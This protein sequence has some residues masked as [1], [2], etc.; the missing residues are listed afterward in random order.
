MTIG[1]L[2][3]VQDAVELGLVDDMN[4]MSSGGGGR[5][6]LPAGD[7]FIRLSTYVEFGVQPLPAF[8]GQ[9]KQPHMTVH[10]CSHLYHRQCV[11]LIGKSCAVV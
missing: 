7:A 6:L 5:G 10:P 1:L 11:L 4:E 9:A 8:N 2:S 3:Q